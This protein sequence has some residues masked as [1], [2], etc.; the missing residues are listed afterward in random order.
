METE[1]RAIIVKEIEHWR[2][3]KLLPDQ[4]C[5][6]LLNLYLDELTDRQP[7]SVAGKAALAVGNAKGRQWLLAAGFVSLICFIVLYFNFFHYALQIGIVAI[8]TLGLLIKGR[9]LRRSHEAGGLVYIGAGMLLMLSGGIYLLQLHDLQ[10][11]GA[12]FLSF[13][14]LF[15]ITYG[16]ADRIPL[17]HFGGWAAAMMVYAILLSRTAEHP[18]WYEV[19]L[20]WVPLSFVFAWCTWFVQRW[21]KPASAVLLAAALVLWFM[22]EIYNAVLIEEPAWLQLQLILKIATG[23]LLLFT[24]R[25]RWIAWVV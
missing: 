21:S 16:I 7:S 13:C 3:S 5:D 4:Y 15:W 10:Q 24:L 19:Q 6:F 25:K 23:G 1:R 20:Y 22:P 8:A 14:A 11:W 17:L 9:R 2:R 18:Q 12:A